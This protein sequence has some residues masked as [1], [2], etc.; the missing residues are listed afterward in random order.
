MTRSCTGCCS[1]IGCAGDPIGE[2]LRIG[3]VLTY[4]VFVEVGED[5][6]KAVKAASGIE[7]SVLEQETA[8]YALA[9]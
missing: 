6:E 9:A 3:K 1:R 7:G 4:A 2:P 5:I 8:A